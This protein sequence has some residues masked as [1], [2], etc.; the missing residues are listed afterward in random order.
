[1]PALL[2]TEATDRAERAVRFGTAGFARGR[3]A[4]DRRPAGLVWISSRRPVVASGA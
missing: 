4:I 2:M 3:R 1:M